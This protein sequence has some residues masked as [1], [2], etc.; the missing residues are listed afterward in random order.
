MSG[1]GIENKK[2]GDAQSTTRTCTEM[3]AAKMGGKKKK[4]SKLQRW[5]EQSDGHDPKEPREGNTLRQKT[6]LLPMVDAFK[7]IH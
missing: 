4:I 7:V 6:V 2:D 5:E 1:R 3:G